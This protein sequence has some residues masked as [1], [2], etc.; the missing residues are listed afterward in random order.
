MVRAYSKCGTCND[1]L[2]FSDNDQMPQEVVC[3]CTETVLTEDGATG[4]PVAPTQTEIDS[5][6]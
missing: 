1:L 3:T 5:M 4:N 2:W 6:V